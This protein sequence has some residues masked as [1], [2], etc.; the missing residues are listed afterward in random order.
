MAGKLYTLMGNLA[1]SEKMFIAVFCFDGYGPGWQ[2]LP[3]GSARLCPGT[4]NVYRKYPV[5]TCR[6][7]REDETEGF[8][9]VFT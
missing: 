5:P 6:G 7:G 8:G 2:S 4:C 9:G 3:C 1:T